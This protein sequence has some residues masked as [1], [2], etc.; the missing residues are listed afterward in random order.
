MSARSRASTR[1]TNIWPGFVDA[2]ATLL[3]VII[4]VLMVFIVSQFYLTQALSGRDEALKNLQAE[5]AEL[6]ELLNLERET[7][8]ELR[9]NVA[10][11]STELQASIARR[12]ALSQQVSQLI[13]QRDQLEDRLAESVRDRSNMQQRL[14]ELENSRAGTEARLTE[15]LSER[16]AL[17]SKLRSV[18]SEMAVV[19]AERDEINAGLEDAFKVI[20]ADRETI[21]TQLAELESLRRDLLALKDLRRQLEG[22]VAELAAL[23]ESLEENLGETESQ[24]DAAKLT[25]EERQARIEEL[26]AEMGALRD[27]SKELTATLAESEERTVL[28]QHEIE[29][30]D[31]RLAELTA[32]FNRTADA[33]GAEKKISSEAQQQVELL[34][35]QM[36][37][38]REQLLALQ[39]VMDALEAKNKEQQVEIVDLGAKLNRAL[40]TKVQ[41]LARFRSEF[42]GRLREVLSGREGIRIVGDRFVFQSEVLFDSG[43]DQIGPRGQIQLRQFADQLKDIASKIPTEIDWILQVE[44]HTD[45]VPIYN[46]RFKNNWDL[47]AA[48]AISVVQ[49]LISEGIPAGKLSATGYGEFQ[50]IDARK[51]E[52]GNRRNRRIEMKLT[53]R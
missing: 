36:R 42:F 43:S 41:E 17:L 15:V 11:L 5:I 9:L 22:E 47:S 19:K 26:L 1:D 4:F 30:R 35:R 6:S 52:I 40:A 16:D 29:A 46:E 50:P 38:L 44:G 48:R 27:R 33:L 37:A 39:E 51:D 23:K 45:P 12:D 20:E 2:L 21:K 28:Q 3:M 18:E 49:T 8:T 53:Q 7:N 14:S 24:L 32:D 31:I 34:N 10:Q 13:S 25:A